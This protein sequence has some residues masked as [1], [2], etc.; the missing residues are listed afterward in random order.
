MDRIKKTN[1][2]KATDHCIL[3]NH[4]SFHEIVQHDT[5][6]ELVTCNVISITELPF[7]V[8]QVQLFA[9]ALMNVKKL[10]LDSCDINI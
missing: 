10:Q 1:T 2:L 4:D 6:T 9:T 8:L 3:I 7:S 5:Q